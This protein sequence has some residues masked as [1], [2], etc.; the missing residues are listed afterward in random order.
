M[1]KVFYH[2]K[3]GINYELFL[4]RLEFDEL[5]YVL[6]VSRFTEIRCN[7]LRSTCTEI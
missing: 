4:N 2:S 1:V 6:N 3:V 5:R 7:T